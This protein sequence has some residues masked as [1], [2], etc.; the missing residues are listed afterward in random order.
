[1][2]SGAAAA[3]HRRD[4]AA[5]G[6]RPRG[7]GLV[8]PSGAAPLDLTNDAP[9]KVSLGAHNSFR[10]RLSDIRLDGHAR[11][12]EEVAGLASDGGGAEDGDR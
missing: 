8:A 9:L 7:R 1:V 10:G 3:D 4:V 12:V 6:H 11:S 5:L 2:A